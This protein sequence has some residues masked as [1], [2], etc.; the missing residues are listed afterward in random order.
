MGRS[1]NY[2]EKSTFCKN[3]NYYY[4]NIDLVNEVSMLLS[5][6]RYLMMDSTSSL[7]HES[8]SDFVLELLK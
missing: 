1:L 7:S 3:L 6:C 5:E 8:E 2:D 4:S